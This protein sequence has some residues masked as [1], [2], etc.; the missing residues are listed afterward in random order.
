MVNFQNKFSRLNIHQY[1]KPELDIIIKEGNLN[2]FEIEVLMRR[3]SNDSI[4]KISTDLTILD[5]YGIVTE[6]MVNKAIK[7]IRNKIIVLTLLGKLVDIKENLKEM[8]EKDMYGRYNNYGANFDNYRDGGRDG[9]RGMYSRDYSGYGRG[10]SGNY[11]AR[12]YDRRYRGDESIERMSGEYG[13]YMENRERYGASQET[14]KSFHYMVEAWKDFGK[15]IKE[16][17]ETPEQR[18]MMQEAVQMM[19]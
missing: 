15:V 14:D 17:A 19:M 12:G 18:Q 1:T 9:G 5:K 2:D 7:S 10:N 6:K 13:R 4:V 16:E 3:N 8:E 11:G